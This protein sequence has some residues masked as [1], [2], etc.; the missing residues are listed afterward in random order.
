[1]IASEGA[2]PPFREE[3]KIATSEWYPCRLGQ[4]LSAIDLVIEN[5][6]PEILYE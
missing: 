1:M 2:R 3:T 5:T 6:N 4:A